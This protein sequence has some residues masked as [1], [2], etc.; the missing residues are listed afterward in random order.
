M[1]KTEIVNNEAL[2]LRVAEAPIEA[3][4]NVADAVEEAFDVLTDIPTEAAAAFRTN[5]A[6]LIGVAVVAAGV[7]G[8]LAYKF[9]QRRLVKQFDEKLA[10]ELEKTERYYT[11]R[12]KE[13][14]FESPEGTV[15]A[16]HPGIRPAVSEGLQ[17]RQHTAVP[18]HTMGDRDDADEHPSVAQ[19]IIERNVFDTAKT[20]PRDWDFNAEV[21]ARLENPNEPYVISTDEYAKNEP[22]NEQIQ[23]TYFEGSGDL[24][25]NQG[26]PVGNEEQVVGSDNL[27]RFGHGSGD[28]NI[29][30][31]RNER[32]GMDFEIIRTEGSPEEQATGRELR[33]SRDSSRRRRGRED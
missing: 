12:N 26:V 15:E 2:T 18:Y 19:R 25:D 1:P 29:V 13:G 20:D 9:A 8:F 31:I 6:V 11:L 28:S 33:H 23:L 27:T 16:L 24:V 22:V 10:V 21:Q 32:L 5:P 30:Y 4:A 17:P 3:A 7:S 14:V